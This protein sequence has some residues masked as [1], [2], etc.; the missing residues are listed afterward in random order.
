MFE[1]FTEKARRV[2][3]FARYEASAFG[4]PYIET[5]HLLLGLLREDRS[6]N[7]RIQRSGASVDSIRK[8][9]E[10]RT[11]IREKVSTSVDLPLSQESKRVL[12]RGAEEA[13]R[14]SH[15]HIG[16]EHL[17][18]GLLREDKCLAAEILH[19]CGLHA[20]SIR[21][22]IGGTVKDYV[23]SDHAK[24]GSLV[25]EFGRDLTQAAMENQ[26]D[27]LVGRKD[28]LEHV[29]QVLCRRTKNNPLLIGERGVGKTTI[30][31]GLAQCIVEGSIPPPQADRRIIALDVAL[32]AA[33]SKGRLQFE[34]TLRTIVEELVDEGNVIVFVRDLYA[35]SGLK[36]PLAAINALQPALMRGEIQCI[37]SCTPKDYRKSIE[38]EPWVEE[39]FQAV[40]VKPPSEVEAVQILLGVK[41][42]YESFYGVNYTDE[43]IKHAVSYS[44]RHLPERCLPEK[45]IDLIDEAGAAVAVRGGALPEEVIDVQKR[46]KF[47]AHRKDNAI[48]NHEFEKARFYSDEER[49]ERE[50]LRQLREK[51][52]LDATR[53]TTVTLD[54]IEEVVA[55]W[56]GV[57][58]ATIRQERTGTDTRG[59]GPVG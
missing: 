15:K 25:L 40:R 44:N 7:K 41:V 56:T 49:K 23:P 48:V 24:E 5:E 13:D 34:E 16:T 55:R 12:V 27:R 45:A 3:F 43:A 2:V 46:L 19:K 28:E 57:P 6:I 8:Q 1:R 39:C 42:R 10:E 30:V 59:Q 9:I 29:V 11:P 37:A 52:S 26:L 54:D 17:L 35:G 18:L 58:V 4:S 53:Q 51:Y 36:G 33:A 47:V 14:L 32:A 38:L 20:T 31:G 21:E 22:E 50:N